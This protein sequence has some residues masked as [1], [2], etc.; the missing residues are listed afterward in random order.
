MTFNWLW[1]AARVRFLGS[2]PK[3]SH[4]VPVRIVEQDALIPHLLVNNVSE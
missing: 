2:N 4:C 1:L 3:R